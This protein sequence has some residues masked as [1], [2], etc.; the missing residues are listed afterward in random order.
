MTSRCARTLFHASSTGAYVATIF[1]DD[2]RMSLQDDSPAI[3]TTSFT[4]PLCV[5]EYDSVVS[6]YVVERSLSFLVVKN[7]PLFCVPSSGYSFFPLIF[8]A[9]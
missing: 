5:R 1:S 3:F 8:F 2:D 6:L 7:T 9:S 4:S